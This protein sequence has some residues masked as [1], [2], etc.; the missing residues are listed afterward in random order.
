MGGHHSSGAQA[1][2]LLVPPMFLTVHQLKEER[3]Q[4]ITGLLRNFAITVGITA[5]HNGLGKVS[6]VCGV[7]VLFYLKRSLYNYC[8]II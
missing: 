8:I 2:E 6:Q 3:I 1:P 7:V 4:W 5:L